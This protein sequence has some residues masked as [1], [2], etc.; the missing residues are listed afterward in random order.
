M[1][2][3]P[4]CHEERDVFKEVVRGSRR[5]KAVDDEQVRIRDN[6]SGLRVPLRG[7]HNACE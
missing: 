6:I 5:R 2:R 4:D 1:L 3:A 7:F